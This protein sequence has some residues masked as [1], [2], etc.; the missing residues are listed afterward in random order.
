MVKLPIVESV[1]SLVRKSGPARRGS[2]RDTS[3]PPRAR[4]RAATRGSAHLLAAGREGIREL[5]II[6]TDEKG[7]IV[8]WNA[9]AARIFGYS[10]EEIVG[11]P[12]RNLFRDADNW[13]S[14]STQ[15]FREA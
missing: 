6:R 9:G 1:I 2:Q 12:R 3:E 5:D 11:K 13:E 4:A 10:R 8:G 7:V 15:Q 14:R